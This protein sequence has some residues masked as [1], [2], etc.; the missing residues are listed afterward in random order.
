MGSSTS[1]AH[2]ATLK[3][4]KVLE[5]NV[6]TL[7]SGVV[8][9]DSHGRGDEGLLFVRGAAGVIKSLVQHSSL[10]SDF[11]QVITAETVYHWGGIQ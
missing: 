10:P 6:Q 7:K 3:I 2:T 9:H 8:V 1:K 4:L 11:D 5:F